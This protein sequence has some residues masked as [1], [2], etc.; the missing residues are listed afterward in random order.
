MVA[1]E[2]CNREMTTAASCTADALVIQGERFPRVRQ[3]RAPT[4]P[5]GRCGDCGIQRGGFHHLGCDLESCPRCQRQLVS[6]RCPDVP[7]DEIARSLVAVAD[8]VVVYPASLRGLQ[9][10]AVRYPFADGGPGPEPVVPPH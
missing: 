6:C 9:L 10:P 2:D 1:C 3:V 5:R 8:G 4:G 7:K